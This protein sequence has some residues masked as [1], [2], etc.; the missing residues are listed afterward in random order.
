LHR[1]AAVTPAFY[2]LAAS[3]LNLFTPSQTVSTSTLS[4]CLCL[5]DPYTVSFSGF[6]ALATIQLVFRESPLDALSQHPIR[7]VDLYKMFRK[8]LVSTVS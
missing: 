5:T 4:L 1:A 2:E 8:L 3:P 6:T 7:Q